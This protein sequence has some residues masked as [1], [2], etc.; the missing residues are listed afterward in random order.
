MCGS[1]LL[2]EFA[3]LT[4]LR[5]ADGQ[6]DLDGCKRKMTKVSKP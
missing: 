1:K 6:Y 4:V 2:E 5:I 3:M